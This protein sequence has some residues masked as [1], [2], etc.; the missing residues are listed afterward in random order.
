MQGWTWRMSPVLRQG[1]VARKHRL[2]WG[3]PGAGGLLGTQPVLKNT[4]PHIEPNQAIPFRRLIK[5]HSW[6]IN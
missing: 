1:R 4:K 5:N 2:G 3:W 6:K